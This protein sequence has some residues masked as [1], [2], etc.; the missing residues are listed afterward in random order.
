MKN[1][2]L[3]LSFLL[4]S[5][6]YFG[7]GTM[8]FYEQGLEKAQG[9]ELEEAILLF[10]K[11]IEQEPTDYYSWYNRGIA[12]SM[13]DLYEEAL[14]DFDQTVQL[15]PHYKKGFLNRGTTKKHLTDYAGAIADY[16][17][18]IQLDSNYAD[19]YYN[20]GIVY[21]LLSKT[22]S[23]CMDFNRSF[24]EGLQSAIKKV[25]Q[26]SDTTKKYS[27]VHPIL[28]LVKTADNDQYGFSSDQPIKVGSGPNGGPANQRAYLDLLRDAKGK[29]VGYK[30]EG[31]CCG[32]DSPNGMFGVALV[33][34]YEITYRNEKGKI[35]KTNIYISFYDYEEPQI[36]FGFKT[37]VLK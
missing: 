31:S 29:P 1:Y 6:C 3:L 28:R 34:I 4:L 2:K 20:R 13:L 8:T 14:P 37:I 12:K 36:L 22:D 11:S 10:S 23:A 25:E 35:K 27:T 26:C 21:E 15:A 17:L 24:Q 30:R 16:T 5:T 18:A 19:A 33:D 9:G 32:Y 7:Q